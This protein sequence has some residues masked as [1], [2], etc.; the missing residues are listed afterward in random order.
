MLGNDLLAA[1]L[2]GGHF[3]ASA[4]EL[5]PACGG[6]PHEAAVDLGLLRLAAALRLAGDPGW[7]AYRAA[8]V[9]NLRQY[10]LGKLWDPQARIFRDHPQIDSFVPNKAATVCQALFAWSELD[11][12][13]RW[14]EQ[15][16]LPNLE[17]ILEYQVIDPGPF[18]GAIL[19]NSFKGRQIQ[20]YMPYYIAR[21]VP[22]LVQGYTWFGQERFLQAAWRCPGLCPAPAGSPG[23][24]APRSLP[25]LPG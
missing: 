9:S 25:R 3:P 21:C 14:A 23:W 7:S 17:R 11:G 16:A 22:A 13:E 24:P 8:A 2:P 20:K 12:D 15:Y 5:N 18:H 4:F 6:T 19:Q 10:Y 1:Q